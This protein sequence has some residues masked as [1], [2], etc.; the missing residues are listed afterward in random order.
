MNRILPLLSASVVILSGCSQRQIGHDPVSVMLTQPVKTDS[1]IVKPFTGIVHEAGEINLGF[2]TPGQIADI[3]VDEGDYIRQGQLVARLDDADYK[4]GVEALQIQYDQLSDEFGRMQQLYERKSLSE[5]DY[6]KARAGLR[7]LAVQLQSNKNKLD[8]TRLYAPVNGY[9]QSVNFDPAEMVDA[10]TPVISLLDVNSME[11]YA[12]IPA[13][14]YMQRDGIVAVN[15][16]TPTAPKP[17]AMKLLSI[18]P[19][20]DGNQLYRMR[21]AFAEGKPSGLTAGM[22]V[23]VNVTVKKTTTQASRLTLPLHALFDD[24]G[25]TCIW[26]VTADSI[27]RK[28]PV[29]VSGIDNNGNAIIAAGLDGNEKVVKAGVAAVHENEKVNIISTDSETNVGGL[30]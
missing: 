18:T 7:Q 28:T 1:T 19:K 22:N 3:A 17:V 23:S 8:Y 27:A 2:K 5:N 20:A 6:E 15:C 25:T 26:T 14:L 9:V 30:L 16:L 10:G 4:L 24:G 12:D 21:L 11:V 29:T 13:D